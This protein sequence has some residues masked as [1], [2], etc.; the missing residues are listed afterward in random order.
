[1]ARV[2]SVLLVDFDNIFGATGED[3]V[4]GLPHWLLW[5]EDGAFSKDNRRR[6]L[7]EKRVYWNLQFDMYRPPFEAAGFTAF[8]CRALAKRKISA[9]KSSADIVMTMDAMELSMNGSKFDE[10][11]LLTTDSDFV[12][13]V[14]RITAG[15]HRVV[16]A[17]KETDPTYETYSQ[18]ADAVIHMAALKAGFGYERARRKWYRLRSAPPDIPALSLVKERRS[19][20]MSRVRRDLDATEAVQEGV[21]P[22]LVTAAKRVR[23]IAERLPDQP[24]SK[25]RIIKAL[26]GMP[27]FVPAYH[28]GV[29][30]WLGHKNYAA[31][32]RRLAQVEPGLEVTNAGKNKVEVTWR[33][34]PKPARETGPAAE[35]VPEPASGLHA[36]PVRLTEEA[37]PG[38][39]EAPAEPGE[40]PGARA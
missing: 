37:G 15:T 35:P 4:T 2:R 27:E 17:G 26:T 24:V 33:E 9:G 21:A 3:I 11:I 19:A 31:M 28:G 29:K 38:E 32:M 16:A 18:H 22:E 1:M 5:L 39:A 7:V 34:R 12:P 10:M 14:N 23:E 36:A 13:L 20:F 8:N 40:R 30:P 25:S 6:R